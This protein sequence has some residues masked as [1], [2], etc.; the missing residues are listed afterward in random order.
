LIFPRGN[1]TPSSSARRPS[2]EADRSFQ[3]PTACPAD[4]LRPKKITST[5]RSAIPLVLNRRPSMKSKA[6]LSVT[7]LSQP[8]N[9][10]LRVGRLSPRDIE[11]L[12]LGFDLKP[13]KLIEREIIEQLRNFSRKIFNVIGEI[14]PTGVTP[15]LK[16]RKRSAPTC[17]MRYS[18]RM[19]R[20]ALRVHRNRILNFRLGVF[21]NPS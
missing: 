6:S 5:S 9:L 10:A 11:T 19:L 20:V 12:H 14:W 8:T 1:Q 7:K 2:A 18:A 16:A 3:R 21:I 17:F 15:E 13:F 4:H